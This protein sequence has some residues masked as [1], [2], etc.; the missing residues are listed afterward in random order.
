MRH[1]SFAPLAGPG[2]R[3]LILGSLPGSASLAAA[4]YYAHPRNLFWDFMQE[5]LGVPR[6]LPYAQR[7][8]LLVEAG[9]ALWDVI[10]EASRHGSLDAAIQL[11]SARHNDVASLVAASPSLQGI[12]FNGATAERLFR[13]HVA[14]RL[15]P[16]RRP[17]TLLALPSTSPANASISRGAKLAAWRQIRPLA[18]GA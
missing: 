9:V 12:A 4:E 8:R 3:L 1:K 16:R 17:L 5:L 18:C 10:E 11:A 15:A 6:A 14:P 13:T 7:C 2:S